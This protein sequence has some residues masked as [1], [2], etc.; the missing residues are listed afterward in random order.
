MFSEVKLSK[1]FVF[2]NV[3]GNGKSLILLSSE[4]FMDRLLG[5]RD[6]QTTYLS[7]ESVKKI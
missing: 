7:N 4:Y 6:D 5:C 2:W 1:G 3:V